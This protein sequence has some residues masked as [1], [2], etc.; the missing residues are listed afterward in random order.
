MAPARDFFERRVTSELRAQ[1]VDR[2]MTHRC[3]A[4]H[5]TTV[6]LQNDLAAG[7]TGTIDRQQCCADVL[8]ANS[9]ALPY[10]SANPA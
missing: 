2:L 7:I 10:D 9:L 8:V 5:F 3:Q 1:P 4:K 6:P